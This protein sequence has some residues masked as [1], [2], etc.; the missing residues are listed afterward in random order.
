MKTKQD[1]S[2]MAIDLT[3]RTSDK[4]WVAT[5]AMAYRQKKAVLLIDDAEVGVD[6]ANDSIFQM[7]RRIGLS[8]AEWTQVLGCLGV[9]G[10]GLTMIILAAID[11][12]PTSKLTL[13]VT[14]GVLLAVT[15]GGAAIYIITGIRPP[16]IDVYGPGFA[17]SWGTT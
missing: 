9:S 17:I 2:A 10:I 15:G 5:L 12:E 11:P 4:G 16:Q 3:I 13:L 6:P 1:S 8:A 14:G 7:A